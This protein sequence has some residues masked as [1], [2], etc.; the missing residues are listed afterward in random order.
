MTWTRWCMVA[1]A[2]IMIVLGLYATIV[3]GELMS[4][5]GGGGAGVIVLGMMFWS[6]KNPR[7]AYIISLVIGVALAIQFTGK[8]L[9]SHQLYPHGLIVALNLLLVLALLGGHLL[10]MSAKTRQQA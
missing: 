3:H 5:I 1:Y 4:L 7:P 10:A 2:V 8:Y 6:L 9:K